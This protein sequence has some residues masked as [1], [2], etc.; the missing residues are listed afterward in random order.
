MNTN[1][2]FHANFYVE[3]NIDDIIFDKS[4]LRNI[5]T[6]KPSN[7]FSVCNISI[8]KTNLLK[9]LLPQLRDYC[10]QTLLSLP[11]TDNL[12]SEPNFNDLAVS[13]IRI[14]KMV[15]NKLYTATKKIYYGLKFLNRP[16]PLKAWNDKIIL[17]VQLYTKDNIPIFMVKSA[18]LEKFME[19][20]VH[21]NRLVNV[22]VTSNGI[23]SHYTPSESLF[24]KI[25]ILYKHNIHKNDTNDKFEGP[26]KYI[27]TSVEPVKEM[28][29]TTAEVEL[30]K[31]VVMNPEIKNNVQDIL[32]FLHDVITAI[33]K[34]NE[35]RKTKRIDYDPKN[36]TPIV[37]IKNLGY[38]IHGGDPSLTHVSIHVNGK[39]VMSLLGRED[40]VKFVDRLTIVET[41]KVSFETLLKDE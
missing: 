16:Y 29:V 38:D 20:S 37:S 36:Q 9:V 24:K 30:I 28:V 6:N 31:E 33:T 27:P 23:G 2:H 1:L 26:T 39:L 7:D 12:E 5:T 19:C 3:T 11:M 32:S 18:L 17:E 8:N 13:M 4:N 40:L 21:K 25:R 15:S 34:I 35:L 22:E 41:S 10:K 14:N